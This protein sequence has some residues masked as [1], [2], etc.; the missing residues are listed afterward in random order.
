MVRSIGG[1][2][3][4]V[5]ARG[6]V[7]MTVRF[8]TLLA[9][10]TSYVK[11]MRVSLISSGRLGLGGSSEIIASERET[12]NRLTRAAARDTSIV[13][14]V[15]RAML[16]NVPGGK[17]KLSLQEQLTL[18]A[19]PRPF[20]AYTAVRASQLAVRLGYKEVTWIEFGVASGNGLVVLEQIKA[21]VEQHLDITV[22]IVGFDMGSGLPMPVD[23]RD[24][25]YHWQ[26]G[27]YEM[28]VPALR[29]R[30]NHA[31]LVLGPV[32]E[33]LPNFLKN[34]PREAPIGMI[35]FDLDYY[36]ST[37]EAFGI[38]DLPEDAIL[39]RVMCYMD[40]IVGNDE[41]YSDFTGER[42]AIREFNE[43]N[44]RRKLS[45][46]YDFEAYGY[47]RW[48]E[49]IMIYHDF[50]HGRYTEYVGDPSRQ[51]QIPLTD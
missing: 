24:L 2:I 42:L 51:S 1:G 3:A 17:S 4:L 33:T 20:Y 21:I 41:C 36:S 49:K 40:D 48:Q 47:E 10:S 45:A 37:V 29:A 44:D 46:C 7:V 30:L 19:L 12:M 35:S 13:G 25:P 43:R 15:T 31:S 34:P 23:Y 8:G 39:P 38:F 9:R 22:R 32:A 26:G 27:F 28:D 14:R 6:T 5:G 11:S 50:R 18:G 16:L